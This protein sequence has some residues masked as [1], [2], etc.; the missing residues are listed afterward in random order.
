VAPPRA[1][2]AVA[3]GNFIV[4]WKGCV[5]NASFVDD[6]CLLSIG[7]DCITSCVVS[8][9]LKISTTRG[10]F[11]I[12][13][14]KCGYNHMKRKCEPY[15]FTISSYQFVRNDTTTTYTC[16]SDGTCTVVV[17]SVVTNSDNN[18][19]DGRITRNTSQEWNTTSRCYKF[20]HGNKQFKQTK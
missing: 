6:G 8:F 4:D 17:S 3:T 18:T 5:F 9:L 12:E 16:T 10:I 20:H 1:R 7:F 2:R 11:L 14:V 13:R 19:V 15:L